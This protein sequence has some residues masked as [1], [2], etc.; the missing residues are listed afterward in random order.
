MHGFHIHLKRTTKRIILVVALFLIVLALSTSRVPGALEEI[1]ERGVLRIITAPGSTTY[2]KDA[3]GDTG[4]EYLLA[5]AFADSIGVKLEVSVM[6]NLTGLLLAIGGPRGDLAAAGL[7]ITP[8]RQG[9]LR[10]SDPYAEISQQLIYRIGS[11]PPRK[12]ADLDGELLAIANSS[13]TEQLRKLQK[14]HPNLKWIEQNDA[15]ML[16]L[17]Q[18][19]HDGEI[20]Y[21][22][23]DESSYLMDRN[24]YP[25][26]R[27]AF[28]ISDPQPLAWAFPAG[29]DDSLIIAVNKFLKRY[30]KS[31]QLDRLIDRFLGHVDKFSVAGSQIFI[32]RIRSRLPDYEAMLKAAA[33]KHDVDWHLLAAIAYQESHWNPRA[34]SPTGV[35]GLMMLTLDTAKEMGIKNRLDPLQS[36][37]GGTRYFLKTKG[38][39]PP[40]I[41]EPDRTWFALA[42]YNVG[43]GHLEDARVL[44]ERA[45][46]NPD[47]WEDV[48]VYLPRLQQKKYYETVRY[49]YAR[50]QEPVQYVQNIRHYRSILETHSREAQR[51]MKQPNLP[52]SSNLDKNSLLSL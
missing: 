2:Y 19:V 33:N 49:G 46:K 18:L 52:S 9:S 51:K 35:R 32:Q 42:S 50:G 20:D 48:M 1:K 47:L 31:G 10:F 26:S 44:T 37:D 23:V 3:K 43:L 4:F 34:T 38:R 16:E 45:G 21:A 13:H 27:V 7:V 40:D 5:K 36:I 11:K 39:I 28:N 15:D 8:E 22:I 14:E 41:T 25:K 29:K 12:I 17:M 6:N 24:L 30:K